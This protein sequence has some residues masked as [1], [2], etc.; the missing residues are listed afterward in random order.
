MGLLLVGLTAVSYARMSKRI[1]DA[2]TFWVGSGRDAFQ[3][4]DPRLS[5]QGPRVQRAVKEIERLVK[6]DET[7][8][9]LPQGIMLNYLSRRRNGFP[10]VHFMP[11]ELVTL[12]EEKILETLA[13]S[14]PD[15]IVLVDIDVSEYGYGR[16]GEDTGSARRLG[17]GRTTS[18]FHGST[19]SRRAEADSAFSSPDT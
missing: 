8:L 16:F 6:P 17:S 11:F 18:P 1:Y 2:K 13:R 14:A 12:G 9:V 3:A 10:Y 19:A 4:F 15:A 5:V 7:V